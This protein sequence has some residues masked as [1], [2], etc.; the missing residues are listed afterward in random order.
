MFSE[1]PLTDSI[2]CRMLVITRHV[3]PPPLSQTPV[4]V[5]AIG[6]SEQHPEA[7]PIRT[8]PW[9]H[10]VSSGFQLGLL[11]IPQLSQSGLLV[12]SLLQ[13]VRGLE[14]RTA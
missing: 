2:Y 4:G 14:V 3:S 10:P 11:P 7:V 13:E 8:L 5:S 12:W 6:L 9:A 1:L